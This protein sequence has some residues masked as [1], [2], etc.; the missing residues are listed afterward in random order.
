MTVH[1]RDCGLCAGSGR[2]GFRRVVCQNCSGR[3]WVRVPRRRIVDVISEAVDY[4]LREPYPSQ[5]R[6]GGFR[7]PSRREG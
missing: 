2:M 1:I 3:G 7:E 5:R 6:S 4:A